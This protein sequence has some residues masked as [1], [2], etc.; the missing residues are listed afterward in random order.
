[1]AD[2]RNLLVNVEPLE[3]GK[4]YRVY[5]DSNATTLLI[6]KNNED[7]LELSV[8]QLKLDVEELL[9]S[10]NDNIITVT[11][12]GSNP[13]ASIKKRLAVK[14]DITIPIAELSAH[15]ISIEYCMYKNKNIEYGKIVIIDGEEIMVE[16][17]RF[18]KYNLLPVSFLAD[19]DNDMLNLHISISDGNIYTFEYKT[20]I[21]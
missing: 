20:S 6:S 17:E 14:G 15:A 10:K 3:P 9:K 11:T 8:A 18:H 16:S 2:Y 5:T 12:S 7:D 21:F 13:P 4:F 19:R 1:M